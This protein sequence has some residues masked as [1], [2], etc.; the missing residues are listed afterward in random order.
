LGKTFISALLAQQLSGGILVI[1]PPH[2]IDYWKDTFFEFKVQ[3][4]EVESVGKL[5]RIIKK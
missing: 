3:S 4:Y 1:C 5:D 2:L